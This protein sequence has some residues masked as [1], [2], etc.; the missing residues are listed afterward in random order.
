[1]SGEVGSSSRTMCKYLFNL[2][3]AIEK[4]DERHPYDPSDF[5]RCRKFVE[6]TGSKDRID[7]M[8]RVSQEWNAIIQNWDAICLSMDEEAQ[9]PAK[10]VPKTY[11]F[12]ESILSEAASTP[13]KKM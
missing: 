2:P 7:M 13:K 6:A 4:N 10:S 9:E 3:E 11:A 12:M 5:R 8:N 1:M